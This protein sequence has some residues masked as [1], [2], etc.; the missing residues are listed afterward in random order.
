VKNLLKR[1]WTV[2]LLAGLGAGTFPQDARPNAVGSA[3]QNFNPTA[4]GLDFLSVNSARTLK[5]GVISFGLYSD[6]AVNTLPYFS[7][8]GGAIT[9]YNDTLVGL[10]FTASIGIL[11]DLEAGLSL[12]N[13]MGQSVENSAGAHGEFFSLGNTEIRPYAKWRV[14]TQ[15][16]WSFAVIGSVSFDRVENNPFAGVDPGPGI[17]LEGV[18]EYRMPKWIFAGNLGIRIRN[19]GAPIAGT[20]IEPFGNQLLF[21]GAVSYELQP[22]EW[23]LIGEL[24]TAYPMTSGGGFG[25]RGSTVAEI[26]AGTKYRLDK[27]I[28]VN[29]GVGTQVAKS[30]ASPNF[31]AVVGLQFDLG[32]VFDPPEKKKPRSRD[33]IDTPGNLIDEEDDAF[34]LPSS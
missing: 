28:W 19:S 31:R 21:S 30:I 18:V 29:G 33:D 1:K 15:K 2:V 23:F 5:T 12:P 17:N 10:Y 27:K 11:P 16:P 6:V 9:E 3:L 22:S 24:V 26:M 20:G 7:Q 14:F 8:A 4:N 32:P 25:N 34:Y 13:I